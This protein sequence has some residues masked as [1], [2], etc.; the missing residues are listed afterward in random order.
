MVVTY[1]KSQIDQLILLK[2]TLYITQR[3]EGKTGDDA[4]G[5][6]INNQVS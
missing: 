4:Y 2:D 3:E 6:V 1:K 5:N